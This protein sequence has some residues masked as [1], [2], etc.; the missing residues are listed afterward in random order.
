MGVV[1]PLGCDADS[2]WD[3]LCAGRSG[4]GAITAFDASRLN[5]Q[6]AAEV[7]DFT[8]SP[9]IAPRT[10]KQMDRFAQFGLTAA[11]QAWRQSG[12]GSGDFDSDRVGVLIGSSHGGEVST[13][14]Q[15][16]SLGG[17][18]G[19]DVSPWTIPQLLANMA[20][21]QTAIYFGLHGPSFTLGS[22]CAT[23]AQAIGEAAAI[24]R[25][26]DADVMLCGGAEACITPLTVAGDDASGALSRRN[27]APEEASRPFDLNRDGFVLGEGAGVLLLEEL[28][29]AQARHAPILAQLVGYGAT[30]DA[31][32]VTRPDP[33]GRHAAR[34]MSLA[35]AQAGLEPAEVDAVF[36]HA[37]STQAGDRAE[38]VAFGLALGDHATTV[39]VT[40]IKSSLGHLLG[41]AGAVQAVASIMALRAGLIPLTRNLEELDPD[42]SL[43]VVTKAARQGALTNVLTNAFG[44]GGHN[45]SLLL[46]AP[47]RSGPGTGR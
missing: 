24:I 41:A 9:E 17:P 35:I 7:H 20:S 5:T 10:L 46:R 28:E 21:A 15:M 32:H 33:T 3:A 47:E 29:H 8:P 31:V 6:I 18:G 1:T 4:V 25:R 16:E 45:V 37:T 42:C 36:A 19:R 22:A 38:A 39:L 30:T 26:G 13:W 27:D 44:F 23:G 12:L 14:R 40:A 11:V 43:N 2:F 34:A